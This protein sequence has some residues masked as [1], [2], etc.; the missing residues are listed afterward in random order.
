MWFAAAILA[1][2]PAAAQSSPVTPEALGAYITRTARA[3]EPYTLADGHV[4]DPLRASD[5]GDNYGVI[6]L[7]D[8]LLQAAARDGDPTL[9]ETGQRIVAGASTLPSVTGP[10]NL[11]ALATLLRHGLAGEFPAAAW[12]EISGPVTALA[13]RAAS[14]PVAGCLAD[15]S[16][17]SNWRLVWS[18]GAGALLASNQAPG[19]ARER[20]QITADLVMAVSHAA[21]LA[22]GTSHEG[23]ARELSDP[24]SEPPS[25]HVFSCALLEQIA[26]AD[27]AAVSSAVERLR[28]EAD[29]YALAMMAPDGQL[30]FAGRSLDQ[31]WVQAA[32][33]DLGARRALADAGRAAQWRSYAD[34]AFS[35]LESAYP[36]RPDGIVPVV[37]GLA[38][39]WNQGIMDSY[40]ALDQY[41]GLTLWFL[42]DALAHWPEP[43]A[44]RAPIPADAPLLVNDL[45]SSGL[46][47]GRSGNVWWEIS[48]RP[49]GG[50]RRSDEG[51]VAVKVRTAAG[52]RDLIALRPRQGLSTGWTLRL[53]GGQ[54]ASPVF[55]SVRGSGQRAVLTGSYRASGGKPLARAVWTVRT[56]GNGVQITVT[57]PP[58]AR[59]GTAVWLTDGDPRLSAKAARLQPGSCVVTA[60]GR[61]CATTVSW[62]AGRSA[63]LIELHP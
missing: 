41:E 17:Y 22:T 14:E 63:A 24:G 60:S 32:A 45:G 36:A 19:A 56:T 28:S 59:L 55:A 54:T 47:W 1:P 4:S 5:S 42:S 37:P 11:L 46:V 7:A 50:D 29:R 26:D 30:S 44:P 23:A 62:D 13:A 10:F 18:A 34:R 16:C 33:A 6:M 35:Y 51:L 48:G 58:G 25:Y 52:W 43:N 21:A 31:S 61:A 12:S 53:T 3:W 27:P 9:A 49:T 8:V 40:A 38:V 57:K 2:E 20:T 39:E 15:P